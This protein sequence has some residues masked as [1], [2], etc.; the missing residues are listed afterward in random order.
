MAKM[1][2]PP[3]ATGLPT[4]MNLPSTLHSYP[5]DSFPPFLSFLFLPNVFSC[6][7]NHWHSYKNCLFFHFGPCIKWHEIVRC[8]DWTALWMVK[9]RYHYCHT[10]MLFFK[11][12][13]PFLIH[14]T[15]QPSKKK[16][17]FLQ[18]LTVFSSELKSILTETEGSLTTVWVQ[19]PK[20]HDDWNMT[21]HPGHGIDHIMILSKNALDPKK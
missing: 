10:R 20:L 11:I 18:Y 14:I 8:N 17:H 1:E 7:L 2:F 19:Q 12:T 15:K 3:G 13:V 6:P 21:V 16:W 9:H 4:S 5:N